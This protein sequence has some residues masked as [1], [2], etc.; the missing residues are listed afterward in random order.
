M[1]P[2]RWTAWPAHS[3]G[4]TAS[5]SYDAYSNPETTGGLTSYTP[6]GFAGGYTDPISLICLVHR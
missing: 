3:G 5:I 6:I 2:A 4:P 1:P